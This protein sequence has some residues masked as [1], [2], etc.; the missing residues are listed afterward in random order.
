[1]TRPQDSDNIKRFMAV[2]DNRKLYLKTC[3]LAKTF[4]QQ[5]SKVKYLKDCLQHKVTPVTCRV[6]Y[7]PGQNQNSELRKQLEDIRNKASMDLLRV[8]IKQEE[9]EMRK[10]KESF[11]TKLGSLMTHCVGVWDEVKQLVTKA[12]ERCWR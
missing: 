9:L 1:M 2:S 8:N 12:L 4:K 10:R 5:Q 11:Q 7:R 6:R 3:D